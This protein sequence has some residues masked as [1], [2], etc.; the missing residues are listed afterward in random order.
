[1]EIWQM[2]P[3]EFLVTG[4]PMMVPIILC[5]LFA[6]AIVIEKLLLFK[7]IKTGS[8]NIQK[9]VFDL[10]KDNKIK[11]AIV[12]CEDSASPAARVLAAGLLKFGSSREEVKDALESASQFEIPELEQ[13]LT[14]L[15]TIAQISPLLGLLGTVLGMGAC[16]HTIQVRMASMNP[17][18]PAD[19][20]GG[21]WE[22][23][24]TTISG[25]IIAVIAYTAYNYLVSRIN[26][27]VL[28]M[29]RNA[30]DLYNYLAQL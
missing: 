20:S 15:A 14:A 9:T 22:A 13:R 8:H 12:F 24:L 27:I 1:M 28:E 21:I 16:L 30:T 26:H 11:E 3:W 10:V 5:A 6:L 2:N 18:T 4:G 25:L 19:L 17:V 29:E 23:L 7:R